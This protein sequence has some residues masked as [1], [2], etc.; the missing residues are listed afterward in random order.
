MMKA[1]QV[2][3]RGKAQF[4][5]VP[6]PALRPGHALVR[7]RRL[8]LCGSDIRM[9][10]HAPDA[11]Y[12]FPP[13][14]TGHEMVGVIEDVNAPGSPLRIGDTVLALAPNHQAMAEY[15]LAP[16]EH[17]IPLPPGLPIEQLLQAQQLGT[18][19]F[20]CQHLPDVAEKTVAV[21]GQGSA[22]LFFS[23]QLRR[24]GA[25]S[26]IALDIDAFRLERS[27]TFGAT[28]TI[29][30]AVVDPCQAIQEIMG[31]EL[32]DIV[33]E[34]AGDV[35]AINLA[36]DLVRKGGDILY[37]GYPRGQVIPFNFE[38]LFHKCCRAQTIVGATVEPNQASTRKAVELIA[39]GQ[40]DVSGIVTHRI[41][42][43]DVIDAYELHRTRG[44][45]CLKIV[46]EMPE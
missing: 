38:T 25:K 21:I 1:V 33:V 23:F 37:F 9:L 46:I 39:N 34:A 7:T 42:F 44:E 12:P 29:H 28:H 27:K 6:V 10:Y 43:A 18:V 22:G 32:A 15:F 3:A 20:A 17:V 40:I 24:M 30:N 5:D 35:A 13:G 8:S 31:G 11:A 26:V 19:L 14:T 2:V 45:K 4:V 41:P 36:I 16:L